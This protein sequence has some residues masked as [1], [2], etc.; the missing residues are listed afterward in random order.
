MKALAFGLLALATSAFAITGN[1]LYRDL[2]KP[3]SSIEGI[4]TL[5]YLRGFLDA[6]AIY[7]IRAKRE[8]YIAAFCMPPGATMT[9]TRDVLKQYLHDNPAKRH[10]DAGVLAYSALGTAWPCR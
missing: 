3:T 2:Q 8:G 4:T 7:E 1:D 10:L 5:A 6:N 9:Q